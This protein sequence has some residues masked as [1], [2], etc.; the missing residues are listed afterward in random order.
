MHF[1]ARQLFHH[2]RQQFLRPGRAFVAKVGRLLV[3]D[4]IESR[5]KPFVKLCL[6]IVFAAIIQSGHAVIAETPDHP[7]NP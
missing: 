1:H 7:I 5:Q 2:F 6:A 3:H 4:V